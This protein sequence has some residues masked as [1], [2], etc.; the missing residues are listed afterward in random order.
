MDNQLPHHLGF[1]YRRSVLLSY[2]G[3]VTSALSEWEKK[4][5]EGSQSQKAGA[6]PYLK[7]IKSALIL[8][9]KD[10]KSEWQFSGTLL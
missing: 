3:S 9:K 2:T 6:G 8:A 4:K 1:P 10:I 5:P 7:P